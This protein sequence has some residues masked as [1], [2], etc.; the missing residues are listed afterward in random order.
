MNAMA[1][2]GMAILFSTAIIAGS[3]TGCGKSSVSKNENGIFT[4]SKYQEEGMVNITGEEFHYSDETGLLSTSAGLGVELKNQ[5][6]LDLINTGNLLITMTAGMGDEEYG[7]EFNYITNA[8]NELLSSV[9]ETASDEEMEPIMAQYD[10]HADEYQ[11]LYAQI[12]RIPEDSNNQDAKLIK[13]KMEKNYKNVEELG[14]IG[15]DHYYFAY[16]TDYSSLTLEDEEKDSLKKM[17][18]NVEILKN[19]ICIFPAADDK[20]DTSENNVKSINNFNAKTLD[21]KEISDSVFADYDLT[22]INIWATYCGPCKAEMKDL[23]ELY[24]SLP[25]GTNML[26]ICTDGE[27]E[28]DLAQQIMDKNNCQFPVLLPNDQL[29]D[30][31]LNYITGVPTTYF[32]DSFGNVVGDPIVGSRSQEDYRKELE[33]RMK[34]LGTAMEIQK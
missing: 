32:V 20:E 8:A 31:L 2:K 9:P 29:T 19:G 7:F 21:G 6:I 24:E 14:I 25:E 33:E 15:D 28:A 5:D 34:S 11:F 4:N 1:K 17:V 12:V 10:E 13:E 30:S 26:S 3:I 18:D 27:D 23:A 22:M 16:N